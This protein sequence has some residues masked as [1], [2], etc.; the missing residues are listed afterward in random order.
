MQT[1]HSLSIAP[2]IIQTSKHFTTTYIAYQWTD[3]FTG[4][5]SRDNHLHKNKLIKYLHTAYY[6][7]IIHCAVSC[8]S[9]IPGSMMFGLPVIICVL[10]NIFV[11]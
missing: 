8:A 1:I 10:I 4:W 11:C 2:I 3:S 5:P 9:Y 6:L 7:F